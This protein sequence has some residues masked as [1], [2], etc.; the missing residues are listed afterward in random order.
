LTRQVLLKAPMPCSPANKLTW[1]DQS[2]RDTIDGLLARTLS[3]P[4]R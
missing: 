4:S 2:G 3:V 1:P